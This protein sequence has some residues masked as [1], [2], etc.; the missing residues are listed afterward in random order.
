MRALFRGLLLGPAIALMATAS[1]ADLDSCLE[2]KGTLPDIVA[3]CTEFIDEPSG[4]DMDLMLAYFVRGL[5][6]LQLG[7]TSEAIG[8]LDRAVALS[9]ED[10]ELRELRLQALLADGRYTDALPELDWFMEHFG[11]S[12]AA[13]VTRC[14]VKSELG[15]QWGAISDC[16]EALKLDPNSQAAYNNTALALY[17]MGALAIALNDIEVALSGDPKN[18]AM[19]DTKAHILAALGRTDEAADTFF[20]VVEL[21]G[22]EASGLYR[23]ALSGKGYDL[24]GASDGALRAAILDCLSAGCGMLGQAGELIEFEA[25]EGAPLDLD[26]TYLCLSEAGLMEDAVFLS[27]ATARTLIGPDGS[28]ITVLRLSGGEPGIVARDARGL[29]SADLSDRARAA[30]AGCT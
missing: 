7:D 2:G 20:A 8:D 4:S 10:P 18:W 13:L 28:T 17:R 11:A 15:D 22:E 19:L 24:D 12:H 27:N 1:L 23:E 30:L 26:P 6:R 5:A 25:A 21:V 3:S 16:E 29:F 14:F 9:S